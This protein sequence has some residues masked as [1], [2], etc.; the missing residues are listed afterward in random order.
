MK[1]IIGFD[2]WTQ[3]WRHFERLV[4]ALER[5]GYQLILLHIGSWGHDKGRPNKEYIGRLLVR[6]IAFYQ[7]KSFLRDFE[8]G[9]TQC[10][11]VFVDTRFCPYDI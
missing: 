1:K 6:D 5:R 8:N 10:C 11:F 3:G 4:P 9:E 2:S 7:G